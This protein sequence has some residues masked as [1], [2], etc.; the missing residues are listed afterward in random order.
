MGTITLAVTV[1]TAIAGK[2]VNPQQLQTAC[3]NAF[4]SELQMSLCY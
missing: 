4:K 1:T 3:I 2:S